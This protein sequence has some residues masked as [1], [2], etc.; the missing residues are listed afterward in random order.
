MTIVRNKE[1]VSNQTEYYPLAVNENV[2]IKKTSKM[3]IS[4]IPS[5]PILEPDDD[6]RRAITIDDLFDKVKENIQK[7]YANK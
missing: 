1:L 7:K 2:V 4:I 6:F 3:P 5:Q